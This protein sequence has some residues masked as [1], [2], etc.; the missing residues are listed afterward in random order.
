MREN[1]MR[2]EA[3]GAK[4]E[5]HGVCKRGHSLE[6]ENLKIEEYKGRP[7]RRCRICR[8]IIASKVYYRR[9]ARKRSATNE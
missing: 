3:P 7:I 5:R 6:G 9:M 1:F 8:N 2:G 4:W